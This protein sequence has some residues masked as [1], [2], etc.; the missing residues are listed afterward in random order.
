MNCACGR[1]L[2]YNDPNAQAQ[3][4]RLV[5]QLGEYT[6]ITV[7]GIGSYKVQRHYIGLHGVVAAEL[8]KLARKGI[9]EEIHNG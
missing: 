5:D 6:T 1:P 2:H 4:Q 3:V 8:P 7:P 9:V